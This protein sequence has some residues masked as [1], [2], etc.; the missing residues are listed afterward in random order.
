M[1]LYGPLDSRPSVGV[2]VAGVPV[3]E[4]GGGTNWAADAS[5]LRPAALPPAREKVGRVAGS[6]VAV[7]A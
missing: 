5:K 7:P 1:G 3:T 2:R 4:V 6:E